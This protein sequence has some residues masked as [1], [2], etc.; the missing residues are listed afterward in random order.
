MKQTA[1]KPVKPDWLAK[2][3]AG[4]ILGF[5][6]AISSSGLLSLALGALPLPVRGQLVMWAVPPI[7][8]GALGFVFLFSSGQRA[9]LCLGGLNVLSWSA[10]WAIRWLNMVSH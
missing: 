9:W 3:S 1:K 7:W 8:L 6:L 5:A 2:T 4:A 10:F